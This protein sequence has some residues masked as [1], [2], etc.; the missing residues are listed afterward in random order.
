LF[1]GISRIPRNF[2]IFQEN[3]LRNEKFLKKNY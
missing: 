3:F 1:L 2:Q